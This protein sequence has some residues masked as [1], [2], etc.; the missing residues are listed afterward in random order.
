MRDVVHKVLLKCGFRY[1]KGSE[2]RRLTSIRRL[3]NRQD[4]YLKTYTLGQDV[5]DI[6]LSLK[7]DV[8]TELPI[9]TILELPERLKGRLVPHVAQEYHL[10]Y[11]D[12][13]E[14]N[15][16]PNDLEGLYS[17]IDHQIETTLRISLASFDST[18]SESIDVRGELAS[19]WDGSECLHVLFEE[20]QRKDLFSRLITRAGSSTG[21][22]Y[23]SYNNGRIGKDDLVRWLKLQQADVECDEGNEIVTHSLDIEPKFLAGLSWPPEHFR[24]VL[25]W[26]EVVD[27]S[28]FNRLVAAVKSSKAARRVVV[29]NIKNND[30]IAFYV[31]FDLKAVDLK[32]H[33]SIK[34]GSHKTLISLLKSKY[35]VARFVKLC[36]VLSSKS[37]M[38]S[39][40]R[41]RDEVGSMS[42]KRI[43][44]LGC[45]TIG[46][47]LANLLVRN[48]Y[49][50]GNNRLDLYDS[51]VL[52]PV[53]FGRH[54][55]SSQYFGLNKAKATANYVSESAYIVNSVHS[56]ENNFPISV[57]ELKKYD[58]VIDATGRPPVSK[59][60]A[61]VT[62]EVLTAQRP[63]L[64]HVY[65]DGYG[66]AS[67]VFIDKGQACYGCLVS[68]PATHK[69]EHD[70]RFLSHAQT[71]QA[72]QGC[73]GTYVAYDAAVSCVSAS[74]AQEAVLSLRSELL[75]WTYKEHVFDSGRSAKP[76][77]IV[78]RS[79]CSVCNS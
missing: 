60:L 5:F 20:G 21:Q 62:R 41:L 55:L 73:G 15:W 45:G 42:G 61:R 1:V 16:D 36:V 38:L 10:C 48:G 51:D 2:M 24:E 8:H 68:D 78:Q 43:A 65:N 13:M 76:K 12:T 44:L 52:R 33:S 70:L 39:R 34:R 26:L 11:V 69:D 59:R 6:V 4:C 46:G 77:T 63:V 79:T 27:A 64:I 35:S 47:Y 28:A 14:A 3:K 58:I 71:S 7:K 29:L 74:L 53:N 22:G 32:R 18:G 56:F 67:K 31:K 23:V 72:E 25:I 40:N 30:P 66:R 37:A 49:G 19:Y 54:I 9:A 57:S 50:C 75:D 17:G